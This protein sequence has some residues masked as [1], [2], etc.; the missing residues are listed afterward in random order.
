MNTATTEIL[1]SKDKTKATIQLEIKRKDKAID[2]LVKK[3]VSKDISSDIIRQCLYSITDNNSF[4]NSNKKPID[5][6]IKLLYDNFRAN[7][8]E[9]NYSLSISQGSV[10]GARLTHTHELQ[11]YYVHQSLALWSAIIEDMYRLWYL[12]ETDLLSKTISYELR[13]TGQGLQRVQQSPLVYRAMHEIL[14]LLF[15]HSFEFIYFVFVVNCLI[16]LI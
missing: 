4:L 12:S 10:E 6:C 15:I 14:G 1:S 3:Y 9:S 8:I 2:Y 5:L 13:T 16:C 7:N 11:F